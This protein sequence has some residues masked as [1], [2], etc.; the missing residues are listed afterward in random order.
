MTEY[1]LS[2]LAVAEETA[3]GEAHINP[4]LVGISTF[5]VL[6]ACLAAT[7]IFNRDR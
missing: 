6:V 5:L 4:Y 3:G 1:V 7:L 2:L